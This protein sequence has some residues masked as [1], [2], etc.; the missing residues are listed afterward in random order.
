LQLLGKRTIHHT[1]FLGFFSSNDWLFL[2]FETE[3]PSTIY[4]ID[5]VSASPLNW[6][7]IRFKTRLVLW[8]LVTSHYEILLSWLKT[9]TGVFRP[10]RW[11]EN[12]DNW[13]WKSYHLLVPQQHYDVSSKLY[14]SSKLFCA[15]RWWFQHRCLNLH[16]ST[17]N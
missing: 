4:W 2:C 8:D 17:W 13:R 11:M 14:G 16:L 1:H 10:S 7:T 5:W 12:L 6:A 15:S 9:E 3:V